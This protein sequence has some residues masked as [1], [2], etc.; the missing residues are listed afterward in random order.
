MTSHEQRRDHAGQR[1]RHPR[2]EG[3]DPRGQ[4]RP[5]RDP[6]AGCHAECQLG[7]RLQF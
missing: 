3:R 4:A 6:K 5:V 7:E 2:V 1:D